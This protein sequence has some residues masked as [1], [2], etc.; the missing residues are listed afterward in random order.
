MPRFLQGVVLG[1]IAMSATIGVLYLCHA[2]VFDGIALH[3]QDIWVYGAEW[4]LGFLLVGV[5]E[6]LMFRTYLQQ[7]LA[8]GTNYIIAALIMGALFFYAHT[9]NPG[10][11]PIGLGEVFAPACCCRFPSGAPARCGG[12]S[13]SMPPGTGR[14]PMSTAW[15]I[16]AWWRRAP[17]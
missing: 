3:G 17:S 11:T 15:P 7:T 10:E 1:F 9:R 2:F 14:S 4:F 8:R 16:P 5:A 13:A 6:E 12:P